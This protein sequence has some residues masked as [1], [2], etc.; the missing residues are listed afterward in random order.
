[1]PLSFSL[2]YAPPEMIAAFDAGERC[3]AVSGA[4]D[5]WALGVIAYE[6]LTCKRAFPRA[7]KQDQ[8]RAQVVGAKPLPWEEQ[9]LSKKK[10]RASGAIWGQRGGF[11]GCAARFRRKRACVT[12]ARCPCRYRSCAC[13]GAAC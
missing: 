3:T 7:L 9:D 1:M 11:L 2:T 4:T 12:S 6:L 8:I 5:M 13:C 10:V